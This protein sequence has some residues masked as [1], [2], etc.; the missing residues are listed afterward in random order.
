MGGP[1]K[2]QKKWLQCRQ[3]S[4]E[5]KLKSQGFPGHCRRTAH[6]KWVLQLPGIMTHHTVVWACC[7]IILLY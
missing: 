1:L 2:I 5:T 3:N 4:K 7:T 6:L